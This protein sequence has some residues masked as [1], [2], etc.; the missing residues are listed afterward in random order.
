MA[1]QLQGRLVVCVL[2]GGTTNCLSCMVEYL[3]SYLILGSTLC[4]L[5]NTKSHHR[6]IM[7]F[8]PLLLGWPW[9]RSI[10]YTWN[11]TKPSIL[12]ST[13]LYN[14]YYSTPDQ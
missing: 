13:L 9:D 14:E 6:C 4:K 5:S 7:S 8:V 10:E 3:P 12:G 11:L 2:E 1:C